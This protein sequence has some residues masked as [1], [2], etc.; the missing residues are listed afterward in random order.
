MK[1][2]IKHNHFLLVA[3]SFLIVVCVY[4][5]S[6]NTILGATVAGDPVVLPSSSSTKS[7]A[8]TTETQTNNSTAS[9]EQN[10]QTTKELY[11]VK[12][13]ETLWEIAQDTNISVKTLMTI[14]QLNSSMIFEGQELVLSTEN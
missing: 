2:R 3:G 4:L 5:L 11:V 12:K 13:D 14:N 6:G 1:K 9:S 8:T 10:E 7:P